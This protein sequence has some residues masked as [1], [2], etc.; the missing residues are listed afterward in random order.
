MW[1]D[2]FSNNSG[3]IF[4][5]FIL[6]IGIKTVI[7]ITNWAA[8]K[9]WVGQPYCI[10]LLA[11]IVYATYAITSYDTGKMK[12]DCGPPN[13]KCNAFQE[14]KDPSFNAKD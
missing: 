12:C 6:I 11:A 2:Y 14:P 13:I 4:D 5:V 3:V 1:I 8:N 10:T 7:C 9:G